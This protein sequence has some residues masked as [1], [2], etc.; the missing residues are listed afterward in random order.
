MSCKLSLRHRRQCAEIVQLN[1]IITR[2][3]R[4]RCPRC[5]IRYNNY[6]DVTWI[7]LWINKTP[8]HDKR[9]PLLVA[10]EVVNLTNYGAV[11]DENF[12]KMTTC[13]CQCLGDNWSCYNGPRCIIL[14]AEAVFT[15][16]FTSTTFFAFEE[17]CLSLDI[18]TGT[19]ENTNIETEM[20]F[21][22]NSLDWLNCNM[23]KLTFNSFLW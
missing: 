3:I 1:P 19:R 11:S 23:C 15:Q 13:P 10:P 21:W 17:W 20:S 14:T 18:A 9:F 6:Q 7:V 4:T 12:V 2:S 22:R 16:A 5:C 8:Q